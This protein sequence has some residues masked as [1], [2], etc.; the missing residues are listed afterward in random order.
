MCIENP[1]KQH[2]RKKKLPNDEEFYE[3][4]VISG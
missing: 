3:N 1:E 2:Q 4:F